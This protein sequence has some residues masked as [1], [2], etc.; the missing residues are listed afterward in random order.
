[1]SYQ[2][3]WN[4]AHPEVTRRAR[5]KFYAK[6]ENRAKRAAQQKIQR[7]RPEIR[8]RYAE[9]MRLWR[10]AHPDKA[11]EIHRRSKGLPVPTRPRPGICDICQRSPKKRLH[12]DHDHASGAF[13]GW[14]CQQCNHALGLFGESAARLQ[15]AVAYLSA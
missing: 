14:L 12:L 11:Y 6:P 13:R 3:K 5:L 4:K 15:R 1:V 10:A 8:A 9:R 7:A 2:S